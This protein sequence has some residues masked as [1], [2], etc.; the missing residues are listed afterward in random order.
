MGNGYMPLEDGRLQLYITNDPSRYVEGVT[1]LD[2]SQSGTWGSGG[3]G[4]GGTG[5]EGI[6]PFGSAGKNP[7]KPTLNMWILIALA[8]G[9]VW[10]ISRR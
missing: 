7:L 6:L 10:L 3:L 5:G 9:G 2:G 8:V 1:V 4:P